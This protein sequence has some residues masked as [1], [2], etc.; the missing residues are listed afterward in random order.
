M[1]NYY[2]ENVVELVLNVAL[3]LGRDAVLV[4]LLNWAHNL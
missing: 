4:G 3:Q 1:F 2:L